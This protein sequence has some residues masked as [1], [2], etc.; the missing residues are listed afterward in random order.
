MRY[1][2]RH[3]NVLADPSPDEFRQVCSRLTEL[4]VE[5]LAGLNTRAVFPQTSGAATEALFAATAA[6]EE[7]LG[8]AALDELPQVL[9]HSRAQNARFF[10]Y[11][12][13]SGDPIAAS[14]DLLASVLNQNVTSWR[15]APAA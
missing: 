11:V 9:A 5:Y 6:P 3:M 10:G 4:A 15:S 7:G 13:G 12:L 14:A 1:D 8:V 2:P